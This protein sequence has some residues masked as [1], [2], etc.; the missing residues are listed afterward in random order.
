MC[1]L[2]EAHRFTS[3]TYDKMTISDRMCRE[4]FQGFKSGDLA[5]EDRHSG[6]R[7]KK[8]YQNHWVD[9][10]QQ[11]VSKSLKQL[12]VTEKEEYLVPHELKPRDMERLCLL[13]NSC[14]KGKRER[15]FSIVSLLG[16]TRVKNGYITITPSAMRKSWGLPD[17]SA[18][19][20]PRP[21]IHGSKV[22]MLCVWWDQLGVI[23]Y[24]LL[25]PSEA[26]ETITGERYST[27]E[28]D[29]PEP[30]SRKRKTAT[31]QRETRYGYSAE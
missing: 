24:E 1:G 23:Y 17:H 6:R 12:G 9:I 22:G 4:W 29:A 13:V 14:W 25:K 21:N 19:S 18:T 3:D 31:V 7:E 27:P 5:V 20:T 8:N 10:S 26:F 16:T 15:D 11:A 2:A 28:R 30:C